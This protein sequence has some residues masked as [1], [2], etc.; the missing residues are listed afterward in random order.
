MECL[1]VQVDKYQREILADLKA[2]LN[3]SQWRNRESRCVCVH[4]VCMEMYLV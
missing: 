4:C 2:N 1:D 3:S